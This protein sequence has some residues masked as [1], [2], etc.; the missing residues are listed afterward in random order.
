MHQL[1]ASMT[2]QYLRE[3]PHQRQLIPN[4]SC[5]ERDET[6]TLIRSIASAA[7]SVLSCVKRDRIDS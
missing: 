4:M 2:S 6:I 5:N 7:I 3:C 1:V